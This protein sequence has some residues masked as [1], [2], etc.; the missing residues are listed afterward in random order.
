MIQFLKLK[1]APL[2]RAFALVAFICVLLMNVLEPTPSVSEDLELDLNPEHIY[3][4]LGV[5]VDF[6]YNEDLVFVSDWNG[7]IWSFYGIEDWAI[8]DYVSMVFHDNGT[9]F[10]IHDDVILSVHYERVDLVQA[11]VLE[12]IRDANPRYN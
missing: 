12:S 6:D 1:I 8:W 5:I 9:P 10:E 3:P 7:D 11:Q 4:K 2:P